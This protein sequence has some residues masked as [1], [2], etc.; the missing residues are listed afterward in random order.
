MINQLIQKYNLWN[1]NDGCLKS[2]IEKYLER[3]LNV[4]NNLFKVEF[5]P[6]NLE[7]L[8]FTSQVLDYIKNQKLSSRISMLISIISICKKLNRTDIS[9]IYTQIVIPLRKEQRDFIETNEMTYNEKKNWCTWKDIHKARNLINDQFFTPQERIILSFYLDNIGP[10]RLSEYRLM[11]FIIDDDID[12]DL[13]KYENK[14][15]N[16]LISNSKF[17]I[18]NII[19]NNYKTKKTFGRI[20]QTN[21]DEDHTF[22]IP[23]LLNSTLKN[24][25]QFLKNNELIFNHK[26]ESNF[27]L[28]VKNL[29]YRITNKKLNIN[30]I[31]KIFVVDTLT[32]GNIDYKTRKKI[33]DFLGHSIDTSLLYYNKMVERDG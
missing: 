13:T 5:N 14:D 30:M 19:F 25:L 15:F 6:E 27:S 7:L 9:D 3:V 18:R 8:L 17:E 16:F 32:S 33:C 20:I 28:F 2:T 4:Y 29:F 1:E 12:I 10:R 31:R 22:K 23:E 24:E 11:K 26:F 21:L